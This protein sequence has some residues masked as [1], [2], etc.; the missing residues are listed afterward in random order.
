MR[1]K[2]TAARLARRY[3][4]L[5]AGPAQHLHRGPVHL[6]EPR[7]HHTPRQQRCSPHPRGGGRIHLPHPTRRPHRQRTQPG[8]TTTQPGGG[9]PQH[10]QALG[11]CRR[12]GGQPQQPGRSQQPTHRQVAQPPCDAGPLRGEFGA[13]PLHG[14][15][16]RSQRRTH[17]LASAALQTEA[18]Q[19]LEHLVHVAHPV[20]H[21]RH[22]DE[23]AARGSGLPPGET[24]GRAV[25]QAQPALHACGQFRGGGSVGSD[26]GH[27]HSPPGSRPGLT[28]RSGSKR[29][30]MRRCSSSPSGAV[31]HGSKLA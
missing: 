20:C 9:Q 8:G 17:R 27:P 30:T 26:P 14:P 3:H 6:G 1:G 7:S 15:S 10:T 11:Q 13:G 31:P 5:V 24:E 16:E 29:A 12:R 23:A 28:T 4:H 2:R 19:L 18:H 22:G 25:G 21:R